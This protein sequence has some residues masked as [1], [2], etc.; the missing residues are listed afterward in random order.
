MLSFSFSAG[1]R[2][3]M[4]HFMMKCLFLL[5]ARPFVA[6]IIDLRGRFQRESGF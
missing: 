4:S 6:A 5:W 3:L 2:R 1:E